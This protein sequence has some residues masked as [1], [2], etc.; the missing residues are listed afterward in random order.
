MSVT[1]CS[2]TTVFIRLSPLNA[3]YGISPVPEIVSVPAESSVHVKLSPQLPLSTT[4]SAARAG[5]AASSSITCSTA[6][7]IARLRSIL[8]IL[9]FIVLPPV[10]FPFFQFSSVYS[11]AY[12][13]RVVPLSC[14][15][16]RFFC[17]FCTISTGTNFHL[18]NLAPPKSISIHMTDIA[19][20]ICKKS[21]KAF[22]HSHSFRAFP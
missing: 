11:I 19:P 5:T 3:E 8:P 7:S 1:P 6:S 10:I 13:N 2:M 15:F 22:G 21:T 18:G 12:R 20:K 16:G 17:R 4:S 9:C 14:R